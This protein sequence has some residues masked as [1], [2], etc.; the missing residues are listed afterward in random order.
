MKRLDKYV[1]DLKVWD[2]SILS[3]ALIGSL[4]LGGVYLGNEIFPPKPKAI[5]KG[6]YDIEHIDGKTIIRRSRP[7][8]K[9][10]R[11]IDFE[12]D[13]IIDRKEEIIGRYVRGYD[14]KNLITEQRFDGFLKIES[15]RSTPV[16]E[17]DKRIYEYIRK[18]LEN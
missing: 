3:V 1:K 11:L 6:Y 7:N 15:Y 17:E 5:P 8:G 4:F 9:E 14:K 10:E 12:S 13:G 16:T 2:V 18:Y